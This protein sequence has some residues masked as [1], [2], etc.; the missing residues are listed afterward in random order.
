MEPATFGSSYLLRVG[1]PSDRRSIR[2]QNLRTGEMLEFTSWREFVSYVESQRRVG[3][4]K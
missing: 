2:V 1:G 3:T 4:L